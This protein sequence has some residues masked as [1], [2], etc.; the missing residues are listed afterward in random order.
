MRFRSFLKNR[1]DAEELDAHFLKLHCELFSTYDCC[2]CNN[3]CKELDIFLECD[4]IES[5]AKFLG[6]KEDDFIS[7]YIQKN[8]D[9]YQ[10]NAKPCRFLC[11]DGKCQIQGCKPSACKDFPFTD[12]PERLYS[13]YE[14]L[15]FSEVCP[16]VLE[17]LERLKAT[18]NFKTW[19]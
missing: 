5:I 15:E 4:E 8:G 7:E 2:N 9:N 3:C 13:L 12:K 18:Y 1:A 11:A 17:I 10:I 16:V 19:M 14:V 6:Q